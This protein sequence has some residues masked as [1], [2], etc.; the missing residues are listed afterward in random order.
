MKERAEFIGVASSVPIDSTVNSG[1]KSTGGFG[2]STVEEGSSSHSSLQAR[3]LAPAPGRFT[4]PRSALAI[5]SAALPPPPL[6][7]R[8]ERCGDGARDVGL[9]ADG[10]LVLDIGGDGTRDAGIDDGCEGAREQAVD[11]TAEGA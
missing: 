7:E 11:V 1:S 3:A 2:K 9:E 4:V 10:E 5:A 6:G 8:R